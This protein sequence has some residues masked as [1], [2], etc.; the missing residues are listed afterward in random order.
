MDRFFKADTGR[1][2]KLRNNHTLSPV[3]YEGSATSHHRKF[4]HVDALLLGARIVLQIEGHI[5]RRRES[6]AG[7][8]GIKSTRL[9]VLDI[10]RDKTKLDGFVIGF[11]WKDFLKHGL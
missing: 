10:V 6:L 8:K 1:A 3:D 9:R 5:E 4:S 11:D 7:A 2:M